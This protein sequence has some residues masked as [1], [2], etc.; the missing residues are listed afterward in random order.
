MIGKASVAWSQ[1]RNIYLYLL[2]LE[3][4]LLMLL[5]ERSVRY[6]PIRNTPM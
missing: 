5:R 6:T 1:S 2:Y 4:E 3:K